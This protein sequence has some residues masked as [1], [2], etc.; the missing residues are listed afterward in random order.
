MQE[1]RHRLALLGVIVG[2]LVVMFAYQS[3]GGT[4]R[5]FP[6]ATGSEYCS[7]WNPRSD[8]ADFRHRLGLIRV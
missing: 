8:H 2:L 4:A 7:E 5:G 6:K 1:L 3:A